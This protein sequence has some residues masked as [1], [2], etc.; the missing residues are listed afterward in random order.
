M[1]ELETATYL[2][3]TV[4]LIMRALRSEIR[5]RRP[6][7]FSVPQFRVLAFL[8][9][10]EGA[11][12]SDVAN[13]IGLM[14]PT[15]SKMVDSLVR[16]GWVNRQTLAEDRRYMKL[17][18]TRRGT[19]TIESARDVTRGRLAELLKAI[20]PEEQSHID[21]AMKTLQR[22]F[23]P[24]RYDEEIEGISGYSMDENRAEPEKD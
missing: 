15:M 9:R 21:Q 18:L 1:N 2:I 10:N 14:R 5:S 16:R 17:R 12:L 7:E 8:H 6:V 11:T 3:D 4:P 22:V 19:A 20:S 13:H 24:S 23:S